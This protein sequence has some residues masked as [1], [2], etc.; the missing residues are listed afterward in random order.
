MTL[1]RTPLGRAGRGTT[2]ALVL[3]SKAPD[4]DIVSAAGG[5]T[6]S[7]V[8]WQGR[9]VWTSRRSRR[10]PGFCSVSP[11]FLPRPALIDAGGVAV[12]RFTDMRVADGLISLN[13]QSSVSPLT[14]TVRI[15]PGGKIEEALSR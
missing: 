13:R 12:V 11:A 8:Q 2:A 14:R 7:Y 3:A 5:G 6:V 1:A 4:I 15:G 10:P 9:L